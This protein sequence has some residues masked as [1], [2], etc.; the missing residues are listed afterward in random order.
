VRDQRAW[1]IARVLVGLLP[2]VA[3][4]QSTAA[5]SLS[6]I[7]TIKAIRALS[8]DEGA[9]GYPVRIRGVVTH[10]DEGADNGLIIHDGDFGQYIVPPEQPFALAVWREL[11]QGDSVEIVGK[12]VRGGFAPNVVPAAILRLGPGKLPTPKRIA[13]GSMLTGRNDCDYVEIVGVVQRTWRSPDPQMATWLPALAGSQSVDESLFFRLKPEATRY[14][15][16]DFRRSYRVAS[17][18]SRKS[19]RRRKL[20]L[21]AKAGSYAVR[22]L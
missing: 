20:V 11:K 12:T 7:T 21:P 2:A 6:S 22:S 17:G 14:A 9:K 10:F 4:A 16:C 18:F 1:R 5:P 13:F 19:E 3:A 15:P 8:Q